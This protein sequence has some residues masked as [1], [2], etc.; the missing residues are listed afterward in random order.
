M[1]YSNSDFHTKKD[2]WIHIFV[3]RRQNKYEKPS[4]INKNIT[5]HC[6]PSQEWFTQNLSESVLTIEAYIHT[7]Y[8]FMHITPF[9]NQKTV[10]PKY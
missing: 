4:I 3:T 10:H 1:I 7:K 2:I 5:D 9:S 8:K 6:G